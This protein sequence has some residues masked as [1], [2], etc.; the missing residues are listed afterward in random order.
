MQLDE[1]KNGWEF[2]ALVVTTIGVPGVAFLS[3]HWIAKNKQLEDAKTQNRAQKRDKDF[4]IINQK[5]EEKTRL[6]ERIFHLLDEN[7]IRIEAE[8][9]RNDL[10]DLQIASHEKSLEKFT[11]DIE[12]VKKNTMDIKVE[13]REV[14]TTIKVEMR[15]VST[16]MNLIKE[17]ILA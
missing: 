8:I 15:E 11:R 3:K 7:K 14:F 2:L 12:E 5:L 1:I 4:L 17:K 16:T 9:R 6:E 10:Q 13:M